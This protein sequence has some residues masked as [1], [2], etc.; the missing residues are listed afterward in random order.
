MN[1][2]LQM[3]TPYSEHIVDML[4][5]AA[6][7]ITRVNGKYRLHVAAY[8]LPTHHIDSSW[9]AG[10]IDVNIINDRQNLVNTMTAIFID[11]SKTFLGND[12]PRYQDSE[13]LFQ[14]GEE[15]S[16]DLKMPFVHDTEY[17]QRLLKL[18]T[19]LRRRK[20]TIDIPM[21]GKGLRLAIHDNC[22]LKL[23][24]YGFDGKIY[25]V[26]A[27]KV[28]LVNGSIVASLIEENPSYYD[29]DFSVDL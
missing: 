5:N 6:A 10:D 20:R 25:K 22:Y 27:M 11:D 29:W 28:D 8:E 1:G 13:A 14:D 18:Y 7:K 17:A 3:G 12:A 16:D 15:F 26:E 9:L 4:V 24:E 19:Q 21:S 2:A 23:P